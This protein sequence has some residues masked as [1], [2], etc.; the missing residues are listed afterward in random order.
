MIIRFPH[1][2]LCIWIGLF[3]LSGMKEAGAAPI[4]RDVFQFSECEKM[5]S[6]R[7]RNGVAPY[8]YVWSYEGNVI[9]TDV[10]LGED[11]MS[12]IEQ[13]QGGDYNLTVTDSDGN[14]Y[15]ETINFSGSTNFI[16]NILY[17][18]NQECEGETFGQVYGTIE[19]GIAPFTVNFFDEVGA[20]V[21]T[22]VLSG[23]NLDLNGVPAGDY[24]VEVIDA[25]G[26]KELTSVTIEEVDP[27]VVAPNSGPGTLAETCEANGGIRFDVSDYAG[28]VAFRIRRANGSYAT[29]WLPAS[30]GEIRYEQLEAGDY[31]L[32]ITDDYRLE[33][34]PEELVF[35]IADEQLLDFDLSSSAI[36]CFGA[37]D[38]IIHLESERLFMGFAFPP[39]EII[40]DILDSG[41]TPVFSDQVVSIG[42]LSGEADFS[43]L[44]AGDYTVIVRHGGGDYPECSL[45]Y[46]VGID[47]PVAALTATV[48]STPEICFGEENG[49]A[50][51]A[52]TGGW[53]GYSYLWSDGQTGRT[54]TGLAPGNYSVRVSDSGG[55][56]VDVPIT[57]DGPPEAI[58]GSID[59]LSGLTCVGANDGSASVTGLQGGWG[60]YSLEWSNGETGAEAN[61]LPAGTNSV[62][63][64]DDEGCEHVLYV[65]VPVPD[66]PDVTYSL[67]EP[68]CFGAS[69]G[70]IRVQIHD[71]S[72]TFTVTV[73]GEIQTGNDLIFDR[74]SADQYQV[75]IT[76]SGSCSITEFLT[77]DDP[78]QLA[79]DETNL[80]ITPVNCAG[81]G[82]G[83][84]SGLSVTGG[85]GSYQYQWQKVISGTFEDLP[86]ETGLSLLNLSGGRYRL[87]AIDQNSCT[88]YQDYDLDEPAPLQ[89][90]I[91]VIADVTCFGLSDGSISFTVSGGTAPYTFS[92]NGGIPQ[93]TSGSQIEFFG[94]P[95][96]LN[97]FISLVDTR[98]CTVPNINF[99]IE[100]PPAIQVSNVQLLPETCF[101][102]GNGGIMVDVSGGSGSFTFEWFRSS[103]PATVIASTE[104]LP[105][106]GPGEY[107]LKVT[108]VANPSC[109]L[110]ETFTIPE[111]PALQLDL[112]GDPV[113]V[114][115][116]GE[117]TGAISVLVQGGT[118][119]Y[120]FSWTG[121]DGFTSV[122]QN[123]SGLAA[124]LYQVT[125]SDENGCWEQLSDILVRQPAAALGVSLLNKV[126]PSC[127][128]AENGRIEIQVG[129]GKPS[130]LISWEEEVSPG[131]FVPFPGSSLTL[132]GIVA[133]TYRAV[134]ED[135][136]SCVSILE[137]PLDA[138]APLQVQLLEKE[139]VSCFG[140][141]DGRIT[142]E[143]TGGTGVYF[144]D[145]DHGFINQNPT[146]LGEGSYGVTV[147]D[148]NGCSFRLDNLL[149]EQPQELEID[150]IQVTEPTCGLDDGGIE[151]AFSGG[152]PLSAS[153]KWVE[154]STETIVAENVNQVGGLSP[155]YYRIEYSSG[156]SCTVTETILV[157]GPASPLQLVTNSQDAAC[158]G[159]NGIIFLSATGGVPGYNYYVRNSGVW[160]EASSSILAGLPAGDY[161]V[162]VD[163][164]SGCQDFSVITIDEP[165][166]PVI[167]AE[168]ISHVSCF[169]ADDGAISFSI[170]GGSG[171][172]TS[173]WYRKTALGGKSPIATASLTNLIAGTYFVE[174]IYAGGCTVSSPEYEIT[175]PEPILH[176][177][178]QNQPQCADDTGTFSITFSGGNPGKRLSVSSTN[179]YSQLHENEVSGTYNFENL[180]PGTY[181]WS[182]ED[183][184]C[185][186][187]EGNF[188]MNAVVRPSFT[189]SFQN[190]SCFG[191]A[192]G[193]LEIE[194][195]VVQSGRAYS[196]W[197]NGANQGN[198]TTFINL[199][200]GV[201]QVWLQD[202]LGCQSEVQV[203]E[204][205]EP[206]R[207]LAIDRVETTPA[208]CNGES[209]GSLLFE[210][211]G[212]TPQYRVML[213]PEAGASL[214]MTGL[215][216]ETAYEFIGLA[217]GTYTL[218]VWDQNDKCFVA[219]SYT[220]MEPNPLAADLE[221][222]II[223]CAGGTTALELTV[224]GG[225]LPYTY[226]WEKF[227]PG[228]GAWEL[229]PET[230]NRLT[231][232][233][234]GDYRYTVTDAVSCVELTDEVTVS[235]ASEITLTYSAG[236]IACYGE[237]VPVDL[238]ASAPGKDSFTFFVNGAQ[239]FGSTF[240]AQ[241]GTY[242]VYAQDNINGCVS[243]E[244]FVTIG[245][246]LEPLSV[247]DYSWEDLSCHESAD[248]R[249]SLTVEGGTAPYTIDF[250]GNTYTAAENEV[251]LFDGLSADIS[252][253]P[254]VRDANGCSI[255]LPQRTLQQPLPLQAAATVPAI[256]C[257]GGSTSI[258]LQITGG[259]QPYAITWEFS[260]DGN[261]YT[262]MPSWEDESLL[263]N[264]GPGYY[265]YA[266]ADGACS[267]LTDTLVVEEPAAVVLGTN[268]TAVSCYGGSDGRV[269]LSPSG[270]IGADYRLF[271]NGVEIIG[272]SIEGLSAGTYTA[273]AMN[274]TCR[275]EDVAITVSQPAAPVTVVVDFPDLLA[276]AG[277]EAVV[278]L[279]VAGGTAPYT[280]TFNSETQVVAA[281]GE[282]SFAGIGAGSYTL[283]LV[284]AAGCSW[285]ET[286]EIAEPD[287]MEL[288]LENLADVSCFGGEDGSITV[289]AS[290][291]TGTFT[292]SWQ[293]AD[294]LEIGTGRHISG[295]QAGL[296]EV[297]IIDE[298]GCSLVDQFEIEEPTAVN[299]TY[300]VQD[301]TCAGSQNGQIT[302]QG[303][304]GRPDYHLV[305]NGIHLPGMQATGL[306]ANT[307]Q[308]MVVDAFGC[309][310]PPQEVIVEEPL[311]LQMNLDALDVSCYA[312]NDGSVSISVQG[313]TAPYSFRWSDGNTLPTRAGMAP[314]NYEVV[315]TDAN[316]CSIRDR[317]LI[318]QP[319]S[320]L[321]AAEVIPVS[322]HAGSD[323]EIRLDITGGN[324]PFS[325]EW[326]EVATGTNVGGGTVV[327]G[328]SA[329]R[330]R[331]L[332]QDDN[333]CTLSREYEVREPGSSLSVQPLVSDIR[334]FGEDSGSIVL[335][336]S[337]G[338]AP[339]AF[340][341][342]TGETSSA[343]SNKSAGSYQVQVTDANGCRW[344][345]D[346][347]I[348]E[349][350][351]V[352]VMAAITDVSCKMG[353]DGIIDLTIT[354]GSGEPRV[355][356]SNGMTGSSISGL[357]AGTYTAFILD[358]Q[359]CFDSYTFQVNEPE[360]ALTVE[361]SGS[362]ELCF[363]E[364][365]MSIELEVS[366][367]TVPYTY[368]WSNGSTD[369]DI[370]DL[371]PGMYEVTV[372][373]AKGCSV[374]ESFEVP[375]P[376]LPMDVSISGNL[377]ICTNEERG[378][379][380][381]TVSGGL[382]PYTFLWSN[383]ATTATVSN[384]GPGQ[385]YVEVTDA[386]GCA[387]S[388]QVEII[389]SR[390][391]HVSLE[392]IQ[393]V[394]CFGAN[395]GLIAI[396]VDQNSGPF[397]VLWSNGLSDQLSIT[398]L[399]PGIYTAEITDEA[400]CVTTV[401]YQIREPE[402]LSVYETIN[403]VDCYGN[404]NGSLLLEVRGGTAPYSYE[405]S[406]GAKS[407]DLRNLG[408][409]TYSVI[410]TDRKGCTTG[411]SYTV[412][413]PEL[414]AVAIDQTD[415]LAC[416][417]DANGF[418]NLDITGGVQPYRITWSDAPELGTQNRNGLEAGSYTVLVTDANN[419][420]QINTLVIAQPEALEVELFTRFDAD[421][422][423]KLLT[424][425]AWIEIQG[426]TGEYDITW[427]TG[428]QDVLET[429]FFE[430]GV[431]E[432]RVTD[433]NG[434]SV[435]VSRVVTLPLAF[436]EAAFL[437]TVISTGVEGEILLNDPVQF[438]DETLGNVFTWEWD[439]GD[440]TKS[441]EQH[442][443]HSYSKPGTY[444]IRLTTF[445][446][447]G[448]VSEAERVVEVVSSYR[449]LIPN[450]FSPNGDGLNDKFLPKLRGIEDFEMHIFNKW[451]ELVYSSFSQEDS[452]WNGTLNG[453][454]SPNGNYVYKI[455][456]T[457]VAGESGTQT[458]VFTLIF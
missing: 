269:E 385:Y 198:Q 435:E 39:D 15:T 393:S 397:Q 239:I 432:V 203:I 47:S 318:Q 105:N 161:D 230:Q 141:N 261:V 104:D 235:D 174:L 360:A 402:I 334:C 137:I 375:P 429:Q 59:L 401:A 283:E 342:S 440:G 84:I 306:S 160:E 332:I 458:G 41:N 162:R 205:T 158:P 240:M 446:V 180:S 114:S 399:E 34:C 443:M 157:P 190:I 426:G 193:L 56:F 243:E 206:A 232:I 138:P 182:L 106:R 29:S 87:Q 133:G 284:D 278:T 177:V 216:A 368:S 210:L 339:Y 181:A 132:S 25:S 36:S 395:D 28:D 414:L 352:D 436:T 213:V 12:T 236:A 9:Q 27:L 348:D 396:Q 322:C 188:T 285:M 5:A 344:V 79:I 246:P 149:I 33:D 208:I 297:E 400:G 442:P 420:T 50:S 233:P 171:G 108:D 250:N 407:K 431:V 172:Y 316:G 234:P 185:P 379:A 211:S 450:A 26:C 265:R 168:I 350:D 453:K 445:D 191:A 101:G 13:A 412:A 93:T 289:L 151:V 413:E 380:S 139:D 259:R 374:V 415:T 95:A 439:F 99:D 266:I 83:A 321:V 251:L 76:Y 387:V 98:G 51:V 358:A 366:G 135:E 434:C 299:F 433:Q 371:E 119:A 362:F 7:V 253:Q 437:Y 448:C 58:S 417:G 224:S 419:C 221:A 398:G 90:G 3:L 328:L 292:Y 303:S 384:L 381:V 290:G 53:G 215:L 89:T 231:G 55:C 313:G 129:G 117:S 196:V 356:W 288:V 257:F 52:R 189:T 279:E 194:D 335:I 378:E 72:T 100:S 82:D 372:S 78:D 275:S 354:G 176:T 427:N 282:L 392:D 146:N 122:Q 134:V 406:N 112:D 391:L 370:F 337:G 244:Q 227:N 389:R 353:A 23:R 280:A 428:D 2:V 418:I 212:G 219:E 65:D 201:Y 175:S 267:D 343:V 268:V 35:N 262:S 74:L 383:G 144:F 369:K 364:D 62:T 338:T 386:K 152:N 54:A 452:G 156:A 331:A 245:Q 154:L 363:V 187:I 46:T 120:T 320:I 61:Q 165:N 341:W 163:D 228:G 333:G 153:S 68:S 207:P 365:V 130:Y 376:T 63:I 295:L 202:N 422:E 300:S 4:I 346:I 118:G 367:G 66:A 30:S 326:Q 170:S 291:G 409:G 173:Q 404:E 123:P 32:E 186:V 184:S 126:S 416:Y 263:V 451:G 124:G 377:G 324:G 441:N 103:A 109:E 127:H 43:G 260:P 209:S 192:D 449:I 237:A 226:T 142:I 329:G 183:P 403:D 22:T 111:T 454:L 301:V 222:G 38:G 143:V 286:I 70:R 274:G 102:Q 86:G 197:I 323:G 69:D 116:F 60:N 75:Q 349:P 238:N 21:L 223:L 17:E 121:P 340:N 276:C 312:A 85:T 355:Q 309:A 247:V 214:P 447:L 125:V 97:N 136:N 147:T 81:S 425:E 293:D 92:L 457:S 64:R 438:S 8:T 19:N 305:V 345:E 430:D 325:V 249:L 1:S 298:N 67:T 455:N 88:V 421:C 199:L 270:G 315:V 229:L 140:R 390:D 113:D 115:C 167:D 256:N 218:E 271:F 178:D 169:G 6:I 361:G 80:E 408:P 77:L 220:V 314:G 94:L 91:P 388:E 405:W 264:I 37:S 20:V 204:L 195:P 347:T 10:D 131:V 304:G 24:L 258:D 310:S 252:Y 336:V 73:D 277:D 241:A 382:A 373:D 217:A 248:G 410:V 150:L 49:T 255:D 40:V 296:Y 273:F 107:L 155:G 319:E 57:V 394:S 317:V 18:E 45:T 128:D 294:G 166:P 272:T 444:S 48:S 302:A 456:Y 42:A 110:L 71:A 159:E 327:T 44:P 242:A 179:G 330:Y 225:T 254:Q 145:W 308:V 359:S 164:A 31:V 423:Q 311:P 357:R 281:P 11:E 307:Y 287:P 411:T 351:P 200:P 14:T 424:G 148:A 16:L 96:G